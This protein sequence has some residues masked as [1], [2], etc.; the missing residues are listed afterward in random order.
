[1]RKS[2]FKILPFI[3][4]FVMIFGFIANVNF[5]GPLTSRR[6]VIFVA[7]IEIII[8]WG[9]ARL[10]FRPD[11]KKMRIALVFLFGCYL[12]TFFHSLGAIH[13]EFSRYFSPRS[14]VVMLIGVYAL[15]VW[16]LLEF[17]TLER[18]LKV[19]VAVIILQS[20]FT[21]ISAVYQPFR[22]YVAE[23]F[24]SDSYLDRSQNVVYG[25]GG[26]A[27]GVG[28]AWSMGSLVLA[29]GC[30]ALVIL[31]RYSYLNTLWFAAFYAI[32]MGATALM[33]RTGLVA[34]LALLLYYG[35]SEGKG[36]SI[37]KVRNVLGLV[38][39][40]FLT[41]FILG[42]VF[43]RYEAGV[44]ESTQ[45]WMMAFT[46][47]ERVESISNNVVD[48]GFPPFSLDFVFGTGLMLGQYE[49]YFFTA[50]SGYIRSYTSVGVVGMFLFYMGVLCLIL[51]TIYKR[52][53]KTSRR[54][55]WVGILILYVVEYKEPFILMTVY[56]WQLF[57]IGLFMSRDAKVKEFAENQN[58]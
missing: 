2:I 54:L 40:A 16:C 14:L 9:E 49:Q 39:V 8:R 55:M 44:A 28:I 31:R 45:E 15:G 51:S 27:A 43:S 46:D 23:H 6:I 38:I 7:V 35:V 32:I 41:V 3:Y 19:L 56:V 58:N 22:I 20:F 18:F 10:L 26:R 50:D 25:Y 29:Y 48:E 4:Q 47:M 34:E 52:V 33:G 42:K 24:M 37:S 17:K 53:P 11:F 30:F 5:M 36:I 1:M 21:Y 57:T 12:I 13:S